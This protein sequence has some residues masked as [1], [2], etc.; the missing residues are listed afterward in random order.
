VAIIN[1]EREL[2]NSNNNTFQIVYLYAS[3]AYS[4][5]DII[6]FAMNLTLSKNVRYDRIQVY[7]PQTTYI[8]SVI[9]ILSC[10]RGKCVLVG[11]NQDSRA[12]TVASSIN[13]QR[14]SHCIY[15]YYVILRPD[16]L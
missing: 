6:K 4:L 10:S 15:E 8:S 9:D 16:K 7:S 11:I 1:K 14:A 12:K 2:L 5:E 13:K 3:N